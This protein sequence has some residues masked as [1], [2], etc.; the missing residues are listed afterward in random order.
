MYDK[1]LFRVQFLCMGGYLKMK[2]LCTIAAIL[3]L[4]SCMVACGDSGKRE[5]E[6]LTTS[7]FENSENITEGDIKDENDENGTNIVHF[8]M[9][10]MKK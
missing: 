2:K 8:R 5:D 7:Q 3:A 9:D 10:F 4:S 6:K 1:M